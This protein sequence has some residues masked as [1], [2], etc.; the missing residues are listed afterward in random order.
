MRYQILWELVSLEWGPLSLVNTI[1]ELIERKSSGSG[2]EK[3]EYGRR[4]PSQWPRRTLYQQKL[5]LTSQTSGQS[6]SRYSSLTD[7]G[8]G[9]KLLFC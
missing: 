2:L 9:V 4:D 5:A 6:I 3:Q 8:Q 7:S 1:E